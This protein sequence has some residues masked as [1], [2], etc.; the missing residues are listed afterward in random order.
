[1]TSS[2]KIETEKDSFTPP[3]QYQEFK[4]LGMR[5]TKR[6]ST[7]LRST[8]PANERN[9]NHEGQHKINQFIHS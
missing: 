6:L 4:D 2:A 8:M 9:E 3:H 7:T 5:E 1:M